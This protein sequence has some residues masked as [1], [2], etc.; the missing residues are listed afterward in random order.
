MLGV[1]L[2]SVDSTECC[3]VETLRSRDPFRLV[4]PEGTTL[5]VGTLSGRLHVYD[6]STL[7][8]KRTYQQAHIQRIGALATDVLFSDSRDRMVYHRGVRDS[9][10]RP[11]KRCGDNKVCI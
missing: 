8:L 10:S 7:S 4:G 1:G 6:V 2:R 9:T 11:F 5:A 3:R